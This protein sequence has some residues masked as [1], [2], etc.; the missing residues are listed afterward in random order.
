MH[1]IDICLREFELSRKLE[2]IAF[3]ECLERKAGVISQLDD[4]VLSNIDDDEE[5]LEEIESCE[6]IQH[7]MRTKIIEID[8]FMKKVEE[9][10]RGDVRYEAKLPTDTNMSKSKMRLTKLEISKFKIWGGGGGPREYRAFHD[11]FR[12]AVDENSCLSS[13]EKFT[14]PRSYLIG[15]LSVPLKASL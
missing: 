10:E 8:I 5:I 4:M 11:A 13:V 2:L 14:Y 12:V 6:N 7:Y 3:R 9:S 1:N 15:V